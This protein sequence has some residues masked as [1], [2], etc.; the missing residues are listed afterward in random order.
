MTPEGKVKDGVKNWLRKLQAYWHM[1]VQ[2]GM[3][4]PALDFHVCVPIV[5]TQAMVGKTIG[6]YVGIETK[7]PGKHPT[8]R[9]LR[10]MREIEDAGGVALCVDQQN[11]NEEM[12]K[13]L[14]TMITTR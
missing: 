8:P 10:T 3:G 9:Q 6:V 1:P 13:C 12:V 14:L 4:A 5:I 7:A 11:I 2:N